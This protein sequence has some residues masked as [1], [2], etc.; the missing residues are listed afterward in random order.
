MDKTNRLVPADFTTKYPS[1][2][3]AI[4]DAA[5]EYDDFPSHPETDMGEVKIPGYGWNACL[6]GADGQPSYFH[7]DDDGWQKR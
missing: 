4:P 1:A 7:T 5:D 3:A 6:L 2:A